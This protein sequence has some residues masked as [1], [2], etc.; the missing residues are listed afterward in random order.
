MDKL[1]HIFMGEYAAREKILTG[2]TLEQVTQLPSKESHS[3]YDELWHIVRWQ[4]IMVFRDEELYEAWRK[5]EVYPAQQPSTEKEWQDLV[6]KFFEGL[7]KALEWTSSPEKLA[8]ETDPG[9]T[10]ADNLVGSAVHNAYHFGKIVAIR[11]MMGVWP[12]KIE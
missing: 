10:M 2:L 3:I 7:E 11:Q 5:G 4:N 12:P 6:E 9:I 8:M 1:Q